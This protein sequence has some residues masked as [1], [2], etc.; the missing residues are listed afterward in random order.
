ETQ[1]A[2]GG[3]Q[4]DRGVLL[5]SGRAHELVDL[6]GPQELFGRKAGSLAQPAGPV[7]EGDGVV[8]DRAELDGAPQDA[9]EV[10]EVLAAGARARQR[11]L[12]VGAVAFYDLEACG[13]PLSR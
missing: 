5:A 13:S 8:L 9:V 4:E 1:P 12:D 7:K 2:E 6:D 11:E 3:E 10:D